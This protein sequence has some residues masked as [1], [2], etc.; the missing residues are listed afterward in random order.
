MIS[1]HFFGGDGSRNVFHFCWRPVYLLSQILRVGERDRLDLKPY[2]P[3]S[4]LPN[5]GMLSAEISTIGDK[6]RT[7]GLNADDLIARLLHCFNDQV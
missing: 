1:E 2:K 7:G 6:G 5:L 4:S 3:P